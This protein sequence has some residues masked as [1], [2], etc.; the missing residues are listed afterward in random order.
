[1]TMKHRFLLVVITVTLLTGC[2]T[3]HQSYN[4]NVDSI[5]A[6]QTEFK[7]KYLLLSGIKDVGEDDLQ[8]REY[9]GYVDR[10]LAMIGYTKATSF[11]EAEIAVYLS[12]GIGDPESHTYSY[13]VPTWGQT[14]VSS[15]TT[16]GTVNVYGNTASYSGT[17]TYTPQYGVTGSRTHVGTIITY[18]RYMILDAIDLEE[19]GE[20]EEKRQLWKTTVTSTGTSGDLRQVFPVLVAAS[21]EYF[22]TN[23]G[24]KVRVILYEN[25][26]R[27]IEVKGL[28]K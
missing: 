28:E 4:V 1:M 16:Y 8:F 20:T 11:D 6:P 9:A 26:E 15:S 23:T 22:G 13:S 3:V 18:F 5:N 7:T 25:D 2:A 24:K 14:G 17:T 27:V 21:K 12:Y 19:Y 10:A